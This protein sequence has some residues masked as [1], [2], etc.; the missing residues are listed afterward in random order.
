MQATSNFRT[1]LEEPVG[2]TGAKKVIENEIAEI[3]RRIESSFVGDSDKK[4]W[5]AL[6]EEKLNEI[7]GEYIYFSN[8]PENPPSLKT[9]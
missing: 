7:G 6:A 9:S 1:S 8:S 4:G 3:Q 5:L 2:K